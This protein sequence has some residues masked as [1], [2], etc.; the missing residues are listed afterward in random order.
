M[1][2]HVILKH[3][4]ENNSEEIRFGKLQKAFVLVWKKIKSADIFCQYSCRSAKCR[5]RRRVGRGGG[6]GIFAV[7]KTCQLHKE[8]HVQHFKAVASLCPPPLNLRYTVDS[9][10]FILR[11][12]IQGQG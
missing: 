8:L 7:C 9:L 2:T 11:K 6:V 5:E 1:A 3:C 12:C 10:Q 4:L